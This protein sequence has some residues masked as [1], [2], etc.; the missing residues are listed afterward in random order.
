MSL[1]HTLSQFVPQRAKNVLYHLP[2]AVVA[3][4]RFGFPAKR[5]TVIGVTGTNGKTTTTQM[6]ARL[7]KQAGKKVSVA[8]TINFI[9]GDE[10]Q[11]NVSKLTTLSAWQLQKFLRHAV[12]A[13]CE[14]AVLETSSHALDQSRIWG[15]PY[16]VAVMTNVTREHLDYHETMEEYRR[17]KRELFAAAGQA[18]INQDMEE[19]EYFHLPGRIAVTYSVKDPSAHLLARNIELDFHGTEFTVDGTAFRLRLPGLFNIENALATL[20]VARLLG[21]GF[22]TARTALEGMTGVPGRMEPVPN[23]IGADI[24]IDYAV[25][26]D[27]LEKLYASL[28]PLK[29]PGTRIIHVFGACGDRDR[30]KRPMMG[31]IV[32]GYADVI[33]LTNEDPYYEDPERILDEIERG[34][35]REKGKV[36]F[37]IFDRRKAIRKALSLAERGDIVLIT[38]KG[39]EET[40]AVRER[41]FPWHE[42][43]VVEEELREL[44][45][46]VPTGVETGT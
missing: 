41:R 19:P 25:T 1:K 15:I 8:S 43:Q 12:D 33:I 24:L 39:A 42:R 20:G 46:A 7:L 40:M 45:A 31:E 13:G 18:V 21:I 32:S 35:V 11:G 6:I 38:G 23:T 14:Y 10:E 17:V 37:R 29:I 28:L 34:I 44:G 2:L 30:G 22:T 16:A 26:P 4:T 3:A 5:L 27:A 36:Y 9:I